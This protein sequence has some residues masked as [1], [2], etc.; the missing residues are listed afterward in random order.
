MALTSMT[1][2]QKDWLK[3]ISEEIPGFLSKLASSKKTGRFRHCLKGTTKLGRKASLGFSCFALKTYYTLGLWEKLDE[4]QKKKWIDYINSFQVKGKPLHLTFDANAFI[5]PPIIKG[6]RRRI[7]LLKRIRHKVLPPKELTLLQEVLI[8]ETKQA[9]ATLAQ[10]GEEGRYI[11]SAFPKQPEGVENHLNL[12]DWTSPWAA[13]GQASALVVLLCTQAP[14]VLSPKKVQE[15]LETCV[16]FFEQ[17]ADSNTGTY[18][19]GTSSPEYSQLINGAMKVLTALDWLEAPVH[20]PEKLIDTC[21]LQQ[22]SSDGCH[23]VDAVYVLYR[24]AQYTE[25]KRNAIRSYCLE[26]MDK[27]K[28]HYNRDHG[29]SYYVGKSQPSYASLTISKGLAE[30]DIHGTCLLTWALAMVI[31][32]LEYKTPG[33]YCIRP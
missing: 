31:E 11:Y 26:I 30:S 5:D 29:F 6:V 25:Y 19:S 24:C 23:L 14:R 7:P 21:L 27:I 18:F 22:P 9:V 16:S 20:Y 10:V 4:E 12:L 2:N 17:L 28:Q 3:S 32:L 33:W 8:S 1:S 13:G 15:L